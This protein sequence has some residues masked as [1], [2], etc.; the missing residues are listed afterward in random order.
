MHFKTICCVGVVCLAAWAAE[1]QSIL[2]TN[3]IRRSLSLDECIRMALEQSQRL[4][5]LR[6]DPKIARFQLESSKGIYDPEFVTAYRR[7]FRSTSQS[8]FDPVIGVRTLPFSEDRDQI[9]P[10]LGG[11]LPTGMRYDLFGSLRHSRGINTLGAFDEYSAAAGVQLSQPLL[12]N[13]WTDADRTLIEVRKRELKISEKALE[14]E[15]RLVI[16]EVHQAYFELLFSLEDVNVQQKA[17][18]VAT[19][20][21][22]QEREKVKV[23]KLAEIDLKRAESQAA[24]TLA[25][26]IKAQQVANGADNLL[27]SLITD[28]YKDW[29]KVRI[30][31]TEKLVAVPE[32]LDVYE[33]W[34]SAVAERPDLRQLELQGDILQLQKR[35][36]H[37]QLFPE[38]NV[39]GGYG[40]TGQDNSHAAFS[41]NPPPA[42]LP[43]FVPAHQA[44]AG[45]A[46][47]DIA[48]GNNPRWNVGFL[49]RVPLSRQVERNRYKAAKEEVNKNLALNEQLHQSI[50]VEVDNAVDQALANFQRISLT[51]QARV[52]A[53]A[54]V[55]AEER[56]YAAGT[57]TSFQVLE[58]QRELTRARSQEIRALTDYLISLMVVRHADGT[59]LQRNKVT[60]RFQ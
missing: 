45:G 5:V 49:F 25:D 12:R 21:V 30:T 20:F 50:L 46:L 60:I 2:H 26:L 58:A 36:R 39:I 22:A 24:T 55:D 28:K 56:R 27:K 53:E 42:Y 1:A 44:G 57:G 40:R 52:Y 7:S 59:I 32:R 6:I 3:R 4:K 23:G 17:F 48:D 37:N 41:F 54:A 33:S 47:D 43:V 19:N 29:L 35:R 13:F 8:E 31:P 11:V 51:R 18:E 38:L 34:A 9:D 10:G 14:A 16:L 15:V